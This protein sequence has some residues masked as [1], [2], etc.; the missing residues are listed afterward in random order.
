MPIAVM[1]PDFDKQGFGV[2][3]ADVLNAQM[4]IALDIVPFGCRRFEQVFQ[5]ATQRASGPGTQLYEL[6][7]S[8]HR[9]DTRRNSEGF[10]GEL[11]AVLFY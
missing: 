11:M 5:E 1:T 8:E 10:P 7:S 2:D 4:I 9:P 3:P 6:L